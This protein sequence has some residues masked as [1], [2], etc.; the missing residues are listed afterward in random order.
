MI[1]IPAVPKRSGRARYFRILHSRSPW[2]KVEEKIESVRS[3]QPARSCADPLDCIR[4]PAFDRCLPASAL[5][6][7]EDAGLSYSPTTDTNDPELSAAMRSESPHT[8]QSSPENPLPLDSPSA[9]NCEATAA[10]N[11]ALDDLERS[12]SWDSSRRGTLAPNGHLVLCKAPLRRYVFLLFRSAVTYR[13][14]HQ[15]GT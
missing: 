9:K 3:L 4:S 2:R 14:S 11:Q 10:R 5:H 13:I 1:R 15:R 8:N 12:H 6:S 7:P